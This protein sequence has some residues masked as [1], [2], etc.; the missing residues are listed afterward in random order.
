MKAI[1]F[2]LLIRLSKVYAFSD[3]TDEY[4]IENEVALK[5]HFIV[6]AKYINI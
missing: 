1:Y 3:P 2:I 5:Q 4:K 6:K